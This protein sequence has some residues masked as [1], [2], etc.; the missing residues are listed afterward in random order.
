MSIDLTRHEVS[1]CRAVEK[2]LGIHTAGWAQA[3][4]ADRSYDYGEWSGKP[5][6]DQWQAA[7]EHC[8]KL[9]AERFGLEDEY[10]QNCV[11]E[12]DSEF[13]YR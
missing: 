11:H 2:L 12:Y 7:D 13:Q 9:V 6:A 1:A 4:H 8:V 5:W 3:E 10:L